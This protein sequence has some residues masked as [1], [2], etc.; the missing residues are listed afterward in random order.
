M[1]DGLG[2]VYEALNPATK[3]S[4]CALENFMSHSAHYAIRIKRGRETASSCPLIA[5]R[6]KHSI[7]FCYNFDAIKDKNKTALM[8]KALVLT[9]VGMGKQGV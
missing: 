9:L 1:P 8:K 3:L 4:P 7:Q 5:N 2:I 6:A